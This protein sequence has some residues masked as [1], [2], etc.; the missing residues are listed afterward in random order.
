MLTCSNFV[1]NGHRYRVCL[2]CFEQLKLHC[3]SQCPGCRREY[4]K[5]EDPSES[6][7][8]SD[9]SPESSVVNVAT[10]AARP[11]GGQ[12][13]SRAS[14]SKPVSQAAK[15]GPEQATP[16]NRTM[17]EASAGLP[18]GATWA[19]NISRHQ[20]VESIE[21]PAPPQPPAAVDDNA[22]P[23]LGSASTSA[24]PAPQ[25]G[26]HRQQRHN[27]HNNHNSHHDE[28][29]ALTSHSLQNHRRSM[30]ISTGS[31]DRAPSCSSLDTMSQD[32]SQELPQG[33]PVGATVRRH[34]NGGAS[35][36]NCSQRTS[37]MLAK[38]QWP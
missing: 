8:S 19:T 17:E 3:R 36:S 5:A 26:T 33:W 14:T 15:K 1:V 22:W 9:D 18:S 30:S 27:N 24:A 31:I 13:S 11:A 20:S 10:Q 7:Q 12:S 21:R 37:R 6:R 35:P 2:F 16:V 34:R 28:H 23:T 29:S 25:N 4:G 32:P 38:P